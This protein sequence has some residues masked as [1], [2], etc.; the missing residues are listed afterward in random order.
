MAYE[1]LWK[2]MLI[3][4]GKISMLQCKKVLAPHS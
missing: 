3:L 1:Q 2:W 4:P